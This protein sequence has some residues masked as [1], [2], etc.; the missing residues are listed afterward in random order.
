MTTGGIGE[1]YRLDRWMIDSSTYNWWTGGLL[2]LCSPLELPRRTSLSPDGS[3]EKVGECPRHSLNQKFLNSDT[4]AS[5]SKSLLVIF[6]RVCRPNFQDTIQ[7]EEA[8]KSDAAAG[9]R[10]CILAFAE[11]M[12]SSLFF[13]A[14][15]R[16]F[17]KA[18]TPRRNEFG[19]S[20]MSKPSMS[21]T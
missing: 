20:L 3:S 21:V 1:A 19:L 6:L 9:A 18:V 15:C 2:Y 16:A 11:S 4:S 17:R 5:T 14:L 7:L 12:N 8:G 10:F 13:I